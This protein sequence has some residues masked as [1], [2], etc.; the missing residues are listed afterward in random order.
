[1]LMQVLDEQIEN[2]C[3]ILSD[4]G[5]STQILKKEILLASLLAFLHGPLTVYE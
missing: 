2:T 3:L 4:T 1:M 5:F